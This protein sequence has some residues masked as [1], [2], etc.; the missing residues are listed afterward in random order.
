MA[1]I[2]FPALYFYILTSIL[3]LFLTIIFFVLVLAPS[4]YDPYSPELV[5]ATRETNGQSVSI[6][7]DQF[8]GRFTEV[9]DDVKFALKKETSVQVVVLGDIGRSPRMQYHALSLAKHG[10]R[11]DFI[12][13]MGMVAKDAFKKR[14]S[15]ILNCP[16]QNQNHTPISSP[17]HTLPF[18]H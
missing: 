14:I 12:G 1:G 16:N 6:D 3:L 4:Q 13:F 8:Y 7:P 11:V 18:A 17:H 15:S 5:D 9:P 2:E 10:A